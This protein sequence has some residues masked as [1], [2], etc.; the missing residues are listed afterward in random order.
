[1]VSIVHK[2]VEKQIW[3]SRAGSHDPPPP[4]PPPLDPRLMRRRV[5]CLF[6]LHR[7]TEYYVN[8]HMARTT[9]SGPFGGSTDSRRS[10]T[11]IFCYASGTRMP[12]RKRWWIQ[13]LRPAI[14]SNTANS[15]ISAKNSPIYVTRLRRSGLHRKA[16]A[17]RIF[18]S[19]F[20]QA[21]PEQPNVADNDEAILSIPYSGLVTSSTM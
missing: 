17:I 18:L 19:K 3:W 13:F 5:C 9:P 14:D 10:S 16:I 7:Y 6:L 2:F 15:S 12:L 8:W 20:L 4:Y 21:W 11:P 1:V